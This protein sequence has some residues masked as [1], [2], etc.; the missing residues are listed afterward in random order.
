M[1]VEVQGDFSPADYPHTCYQGDV[2][3]RPEHVAPCP[4]RLVTLVACHSDPVLLVRSAFARPRGG[5]KL[6]VSAAPAAPA[7]VFRQG[8][9]QVASG[10]AGWMNATN[11]F[12]DGHVYFVVSI[13]LLFSSKDNCL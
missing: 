7:R 4:A 11:G 10:M 9:A 1:Y 6:V 13:R 2:R 3:T 5:I 12:A 8:T